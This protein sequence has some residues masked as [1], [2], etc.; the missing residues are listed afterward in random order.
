MIYLKTLKS[1]TVSMWGLRLVLLFRTHAFKGVER[2]GLLIA[3]VEDNDF[4]AE[5]HV[6]VHWSL[7]I[8]EEGRTPLTLFAPGL[9]GFS[10]VLTRH[11]IK[12][13]CMFYFRK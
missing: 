6:R 2:V 12:R 4:P 11:L 7:G 9:E 13:N 1:L 10:A 3:V 5:P 8:V